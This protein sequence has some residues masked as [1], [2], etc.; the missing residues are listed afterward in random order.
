MLY[1]LVP[2]CGSEFAERNTDFFLFFKVAAEYLKEL[3]YVWGS[4]RKLILE[5]PFNS[6][7]NKKEWEAKSP[8]NVF[9]VGL[10]HSVSLFY[11]CSVYKNAGGA[12]E[13][14]GMFI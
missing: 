5:L 11:K 14:G 10:L 8:L 2:L 4:C 3:E 1:L 6:Q 7:G 12:G 9:H 13:G